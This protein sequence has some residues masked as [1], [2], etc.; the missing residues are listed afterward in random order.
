VLV[1]KRS[2]SIRG[3]GKQK[4]FWAKSVVVVRRDR[5][6]PISTLLRFICK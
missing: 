6:G 1:F 4:V 2:G 3:K 5:L